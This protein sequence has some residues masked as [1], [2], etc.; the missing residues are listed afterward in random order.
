MTDP[1]FAIIRK[2]LEE[3]PAQCRYHGDATAPSDRG[4]L[5]GREAC[6]D[7]GVPAQ[8]R[9]VAEQA[10]RNLAAVSA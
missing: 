4:R 3:L 1:G 10:L 9:K 5:F 8:R 2:A 6:C 7:T